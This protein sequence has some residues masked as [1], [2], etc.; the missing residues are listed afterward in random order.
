MGKCIPYKNVLL[1]RF[2]NSL[3]NIAVLSKVGSIPASST[4][5]MQIMF[6]RT[7]SGGKPEFTATEVASGTL[8]L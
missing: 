5:D 6:N 2:Q 3:L 7:L 8:E 1:V 4:W